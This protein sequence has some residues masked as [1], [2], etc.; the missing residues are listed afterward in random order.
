MTAVTDLLRITPPLQR[1]AMGLL[2]IA[3]TLIGVSCAKTST[4]TIASEVSESV[5]IASADEAEVVVQDQLSGRA[6]GF[7]GKTISL[8]GEVRATIGDTS[9]LIEDERLFGGADILIINIGEPITILD[10]DESDVQ[11]IG[12]V[13]QLVLADLERDYGIKLDPELYGEYENRPIII[14]QIVVLAPGPG[15]LTSSP[16]KYYDQRI[17]VTGEVDD[18]LSSNIFTLDEEQFFGG[19]D[20]LVIYPNA[21]AQAEDDQEVIVTG[22]LRRYGKEAFERDYALD[23]S[24]SVQAKIDAE[25]ADKPILIAD[26]IHRLTP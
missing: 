20:L 9:F 1:M 16:E 23:W 17:A 24:D 18:I 13:R 11:V 21:M 19:E 8:R 12:I 14:A 6:D 15:E 26:D 2:L 25:Y 3:T 10:G 4:Q 7:I 5:A 22:V